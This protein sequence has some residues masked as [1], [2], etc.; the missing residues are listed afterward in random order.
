MIN[1][2]YEGMPVR[3][4]DEFTLNRVVPGKR[5]GIIKEIAH[6]KQTGVPAVLIE[7]TDGSRMGMFALHCRLQM[8]KNE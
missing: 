8:S 1:D 2:L 5:T 3:W 6:H 4:A 7:F